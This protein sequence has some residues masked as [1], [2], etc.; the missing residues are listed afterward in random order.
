MI[1]S[2]KTQPIFKGPWVQKSKLFM[3]RFVGSLMCSA[4]WRGGRLMIC[5]WGQRANTA[6]APSAPLTIRKVGCKERNIWIGFPRICGFWW[7][8]WMW[9]RCTFRHKIIIWMSQPVLSS[10]VHN[11]CLLIN[12]NTRLFP[13][14]CRSTHLSKLRGC[15]FFICFMLLIKNIEMSFCET[16]ANSRWGFLVRM[17]GEALTALFASCWIKECQVHIL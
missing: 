3:R 9:W 11:Q 8:R 16:C 12:D 14:S 15:L 5:R 10:T 1:I 13:I 2:I 17:T 7:W 4:T 6:Q